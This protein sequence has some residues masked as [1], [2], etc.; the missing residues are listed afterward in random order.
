[1]QLLAMIAICLMLSGCVSSSATH[2]ADGS[3]GHVISCPSPGG[4]VGAMTDWG[5]CFQKAGELCQTRGYT[6]L[7]K[8]G[9]AGFTAAV[10]QY[11]G[12]A[13]STASRSMIIKCNDAIPG[14]GRG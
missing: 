3:S 13:S 9:E 7:H 10:S 12:G 5:T 1:M 6:V 4:L 8:S 14:A 2:L 11:G